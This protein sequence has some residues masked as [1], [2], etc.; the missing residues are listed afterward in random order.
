MD[1]FATKTLTS[2]SMKSPYKKD[3]LYFFVNKRPVNLGKKFTLLLSQAYKQHNPNAKYLVL[4][5]LTL[6]P[7][8]VWKFYNIWKCV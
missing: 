2:G 8:N 1:G 4:L 5:N 3:M 7:G 6:P